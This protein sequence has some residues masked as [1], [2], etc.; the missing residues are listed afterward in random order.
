MKYLVLTQAEE[1]ETIEA[2]IAQDYEFAEV[3]LSVF[4][5]KCD[6]EGKMPLIAAVF[7]VPD[8]YIL[9]GNYKETNKIY[10]RIYEER[11]K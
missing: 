6:S 7:T 1:D 5:K 10:K 4:R 3:I 9:R 11:K 2:L 8:S